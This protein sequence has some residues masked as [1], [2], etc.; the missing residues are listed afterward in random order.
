MYKETGRIIAVLGIQKGIS[1]KTGNEWASQVFV[2]ETAERFP[3]RV[4]Y[5]IIGADRINAAALK[6]GET[7]DVYGEVRAHEYNSNWYNEIVAV[8]ILVNN[9]SRFVPV[10]I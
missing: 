1:S 4:S 6:L 10:R 8:D 9:L 7:V 3:R 5:S 2:I